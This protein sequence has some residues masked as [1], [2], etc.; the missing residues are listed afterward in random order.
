MQSASLIVLV[1]AFADGIGVFEDP[2]LDGFVLAWLHEYG[3]RF[4][5]R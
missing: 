4:N 2:G 3:F 1:G 5:V